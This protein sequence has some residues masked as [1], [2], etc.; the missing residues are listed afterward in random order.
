MSASTQAHSP[1]T[2]EAA[3]RGHAASRT[4]LGDDLAAVHLAA[5]VSRL[6]G[7]HAVTL[8]DAGPDLALAAARE[9]L[10]THIADDDAPRSRTTLLEAC[11]LLDD[12]EAAQ[13]V[14]EDV[15]LRS[16]TAELDRIQAAVDELLDLDP[17]DAVDRAP[18]LY[19]TSCDMG[20]GMISSVTGSV[21]VPRQLSVIPGAQQADHVAEF[22]EFMASA[23]IPLV[24]T[25][26]EAELV[27][28]RVPALINDAEQ[29]ERTF[30]GIVR[31]AR[32]SS[33]VVA[34][35][36]TQGRAIGFLHGDRPLDRDHVVELDRDRI[37]SFA[38]CFGLA[39]EHTLLRARL[40]EQR[41]RS[42]AAFLET[43]G[44][45]EALETA[46]V[47]LVDALRSAAEVADPRQASPQDLTARRVHDLLTAREREVLA[48]MTEGATNS[49][50]AEQLVIAEGTVKSH[51]KNIL[52]KL[53]SP[54]RSAAVARYAQLTRRSSLA[55]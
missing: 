43:D 36:M 2:T 17:V 9:R 20:R 40:A 14:R 4:G 41:R 50:I 24:H 13:S 34:P 39:H 12:V 31:A 35:I 7:V 45:L 21:W 46:E 37:A 8:D 19:S 10:E 49:R 53:R 30:K 33:Y 44:L 18:E 42:R 55:A 11:R 5:R 47:R 38:T 1:S 29:D 52:R 54:T 26:I 15:A 23:R 27:R 3:L 16:R 6:L 28:R 25:M 22:L 32:A 51:V 48:L